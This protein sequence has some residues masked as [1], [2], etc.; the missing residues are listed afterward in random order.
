MSLSLLVALLTFSTTAA[1]R[2]GLYVIPLQLFLCGR[3]GKLGR[4]FESMAVLAYA[5][6]MAVW[7][8]FATH[9]YAWLPYQF[10]PFT[11]ELEAIQNSE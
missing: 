4:E 5:A 8:G 10:L 3:I 1:D 11:T 9:A 6:T 2:M 7:L